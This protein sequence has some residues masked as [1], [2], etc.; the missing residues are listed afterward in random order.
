[1]KTT[2]L[3][4]RIDPGIHKKFT[5]LCKARQRKKSDI[6]EMLVTEYVKHAD[7]NGW[8]EYVT[9]RCTACQKEFKQDRL[10]QK[11]W[12]SPECHLLC[13]IYWKELKQKR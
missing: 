11:S 7:E 5:A 10:K 12:C 3:T 9:S 2:N 4:A 13:A 6:I 8:T 1:M